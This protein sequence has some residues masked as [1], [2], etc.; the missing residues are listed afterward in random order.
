MMEKTFASRVKSFRKTHQLTQEDFVRIYPDITL[1]TLRNWEQCR[2]Q[3][4]P[5]DVVDALFRVIERYPALV[6]SVAL[7]MLSI[8]RELRSVGEDAQ[9]NSMNLREGLRAKYGLSD[10]ELRARETVLSQ[11]LA[12]DLFHLLRGKK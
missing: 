7:D 11:S 4:P 6:A 5:S 9:Y 2:R 8:V 3:A 12:T 10:I 1:A